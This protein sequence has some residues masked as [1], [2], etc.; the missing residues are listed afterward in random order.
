MDGL[1]FDEVDADDLSL[2]LAVHDY[3]VIGN[4]GADTGQVD[5]DVALLDRHRNDGHRRWCNRHKRGLLKWPVMGGGETTDNCDHRSRQSGRNDKPSAHLLSSPVCEILLSRNQWA[6]S[7]RS[8][9]SFRWSKSFRSSAT[10]PGSRWNW[11]P[12]S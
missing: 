2:D 10:G 1:P 6:R 4:H 8:A 12:R 11:V 3:R 9:N 5:R 7:S